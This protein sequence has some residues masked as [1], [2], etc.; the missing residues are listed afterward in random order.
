MVLID[1]I[2]VFVDEVAVGV[3]EFNMDQINVDKVGS[4]KQTGQ[5][6]TIN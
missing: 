4:Y 3:S 6:G 5:A 1:L 2:N